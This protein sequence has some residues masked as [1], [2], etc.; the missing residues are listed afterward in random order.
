MMQH[1]VITKTSHDSQPVRFE[2]LYGFKIAAI[3]HELSVILTVFQSYFILQNTTVSA[4]K[5]F[6]VLLKKRCH[7]RTF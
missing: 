1:A 5:L 6:N 3:H 4:R 7:L 2:I